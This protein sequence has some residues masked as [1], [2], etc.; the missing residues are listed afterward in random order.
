MLRRGDPDFSR[1]VVIDA[2]PERVWRALTDPAELKQWMADPKVGVEVSTT[3]EVGSPI[4]VTGFHVT[5]F[6]NSGVVEHFEPPRRLRYTHL[7]SISKL[8]DKP[9]NHAVFEFRLE[10]AGP[11][12]TLT[13]TV[14]TCATPSI[15]KHLEF[16]WNGTTGVLKRF[17]ETGSARLNLT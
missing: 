16:Y 17:I 14:S 10:A 7:S 2:P 8:A 9:E 1:T 3:W 15:F 11:Q 6:V 5:R 12:T 13:V 4:R